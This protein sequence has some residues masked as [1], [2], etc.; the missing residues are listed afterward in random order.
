MEKDMG[1]THK[2]IDYTGQIFG[3]YEIISFDTIRTFPGGQRKKYWNVRCIHCSN[4]KSLC[5]TKIIGKE[6]N[7]C[8]SCVKDRFSGCNNHLWKNQN[9]TNV[10]SM[11]FHKLKGCALKRNLEFNLTR[12]DLDKLFENQNR[13]CVYTKYD[14]YF[15]NNKIRGTAS[16]DRIDSSKGYVHDNVQWVHK[17]V[18]TIKWDLTHDKFLEI[19]KLITENYKNA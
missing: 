19:C 1:C 7:G 12:E 16:L 15:G 17:D 8:S 13:K 18:N 3:C 5:Y 10:P 6:Q 11:Y 4:K 14:L 9:V 2:G